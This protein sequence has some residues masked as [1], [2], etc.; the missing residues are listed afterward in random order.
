LLKAEA[1]AEAFVGA[2]AGDAVGR[3]QGYYMHFPG[4]GY[5]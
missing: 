4:A 2:Y 1:G 3:K 5:T